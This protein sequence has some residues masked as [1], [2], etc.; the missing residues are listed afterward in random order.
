M[1]ENEHKGRFFLHTFYYDFLIAGGCNFDLF[2]AYSK[3]Y[4]YKSNGSSFLLRSRG[5]DGKAY[6]ADDIVVKGGISSL[7]KKKASSLLEKLEK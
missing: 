1:N 6:T 5:R 4:I 3:P 7:P 2:S